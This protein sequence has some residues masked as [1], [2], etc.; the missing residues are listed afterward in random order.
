MSWIA[1]NN[2]PEPYAEI[3]LVIWSFQARFAGRF[4]G[5]PGQSWM[6]CEP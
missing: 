2:A 5:G 6:R 1:P 3:E 4:R